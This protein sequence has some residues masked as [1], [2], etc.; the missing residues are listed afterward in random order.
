MPIKAFEELNDSLLAT[1]DR[2]FA[3]PRNAAAGSL[4]M[5]DPK[6]TAS[7]QLVFVPHGIGL[8][9][10]RRF[11]TFSEQVDVLR[12][13]GFRGAGKRE[14]SDDIEKVFE[15]CVDW[16]EDRHDVPF[17]VDGVV[18][19]VEDLDQRDELGYTSKSPR[20][21]IAYKF[22]PEE[23][24]TRLLD[25][26]VSIGRTGAATPFARLEPVRLS[27]ATVTTATL[28]N[29]EEI[30]RKDIR[31]GDIVIARRAGDVIPEVVIPV[32][33]KRTGKER[34][35]KMPK[36]CPRCKS[37]LERP[38]GE[39]VWR[40][41]NESC[42]SRQVESLMHFAGRSAMDIDRLGYKT[43][44]E[45]WERGW[46]KDLADIYFVG[47][48]QLLELPLFADKKAD[49]LVSGIEDSKSRGLARVLVGLGIRHV[50]PPTARLLAQKFGT[51]DEIAKASDEALQEIDGIGPTVVEAL[52]KF[53][54]SKANLRM[55]D[56]LREAGVTLT[57]EIA[58]LVE[59][60]LSGKTLVLTGG[61]E[62]LSRDEA[63]AAIE[64][65][66][67]KVTSSVSKKTDF[68]VAGE[69][70]GT[71]LAKAQDLGVAILDERGLLDLL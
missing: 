5:K 11:R 37:A 15:I 51:I 6:V 41:P 27:G 7:R 65:A 22:P 56:K 59:G 61:L 21:A 70:P 67:G 13:F 60:P 26:M 69:N 35:F 44:I 64:A 20:W 16:Q 48:D 17:E 54:N 3:N 36:N 71:K 30:A 24:T 31:I 66:G 34:K 2:P 63:K 39:K 9:E 40:C 53:F 47:R 49:Q 33:S 58:A 14:I 8:V 32:V 12:D 68:V 55:I 43:V 25:I 46:V 19:K 10:G 42:P 23:R 4:R 52:R 50:G 45:L 62:S 29:P 28:H 38:E 1:Q 57:E 18:V